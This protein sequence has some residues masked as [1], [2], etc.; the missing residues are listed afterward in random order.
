MKFSRAASEEAFTPH[1]ELEAPDLAAFATMD[2]AEFKVR[3]GDTPLMRAKR[4][5]L[6]RNASTVLHNANA[7]GS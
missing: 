3:C 7:A 2:D 1:A 5:G 4:A 6:Q